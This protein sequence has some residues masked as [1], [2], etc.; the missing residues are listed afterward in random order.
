MRFLQNLPGQSLT[1]LSFCFGVDSSVVARWIKKGLMKTQKRGTARTEDQGGD[2]YYI[3][4]I[5]VRNFIVDNVGILDFRK[6]D[7]YW[8]VDLLSGGAIGTGPS[9]ADN[10]I[11]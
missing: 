1:S 11:G 5:W 10:V 8:L 4:D 9:K 2:S 3:K 6:I 7:K